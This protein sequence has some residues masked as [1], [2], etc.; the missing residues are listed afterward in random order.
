MEVDS[1]RQMDY[2]FKLQQGLTDMRQQQEE[3]VKLYKDEM[4][5]TYVA[6]VS[7]LL[8]KHTP[9]INTNFSFKNPL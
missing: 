4:E 7:N 9:H 5:T 8:H 6:K 3:Q 2:E 1:G